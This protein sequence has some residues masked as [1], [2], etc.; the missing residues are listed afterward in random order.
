MASK[1]RRESVEGRVEG[2]FNMEEDP[3]ASWR[4][5]LKQMVTSSIYGGALSLASG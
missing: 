1:D 4:Y 5:S 2:N 3:P